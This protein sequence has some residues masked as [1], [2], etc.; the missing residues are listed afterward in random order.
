MAT[1]TSRIARLACGLRHAIGS[2][3]LLACATVAHA[4]VFGE[5]DRVMLELGPYVYHRIDN[6]GHNQWP[7]LVGMEYESVSHWLGGAVSFRNS[8]YQNAAYVY[9]G[10]RWF[11]DAVDENLYLKVTAGFVYGYK[12][13][14]EDKLPVNHN[15]YGFGI[16]PALG[17]QFGRANAQI[18]FLG[19]TA[20]AFTVG[21]DLWN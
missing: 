15:G 8:Y 14:Y 9:A 21:Y 6:T 3:S 20:L 18:V 7:R 11:I 16:V 19:A 17:Y 13:P 4:D 2:L 1:G 10:R 12:K 5:G